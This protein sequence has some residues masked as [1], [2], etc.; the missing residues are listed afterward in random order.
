MFIILV[1]R[2]L[3]GEL[4]HFRYTVFVAVLH[5][6]RFHT[7]RRVRIRFGGKT[8]NPW[9]YKQKQIANRQPRRATGRLDIRLTYTWDYL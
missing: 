8:Q 4:S 7:S 5:R 2:W 3:A 6:L 9:S 1:N